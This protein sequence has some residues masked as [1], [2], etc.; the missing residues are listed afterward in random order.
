[1]M[2]RMS[3]APCVG[4]GGLG[5]R[6]GWRAPCTLGR[7]LVRQHRPDCELR[8]WHG[9]GNRARA[10]ACGTMKRVDA[11]IPLLAT[12]SAMPAGTGRDRRRRGVLRTVAVWL[13]GALGM[14]LS[15]AV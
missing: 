2:H 5:V 7:R 15:G 1:M 8:G 11:A 4:L 12:T 3:V 14:P 9:E 13:Q 10:L 6:D